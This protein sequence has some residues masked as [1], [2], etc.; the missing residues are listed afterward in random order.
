V[1]VGW[2]TPVYNFLDSVPSSPTLNQGSCADWS[3]SAL[4]PLKNEGF[5]VPTQV[6]YVVKGGPLWLPGEKIPGSAMVVNNFLRNGYLWDTVRVMGGA[7]GGFSSFSRASGLFS[8][9]SYRDPNLVGT[10]EAYDKAAD[11]LVQA[12]V[13]QDELS[14]SI[15]GTIG[16][17][18]SP[19]SPDQKG[20][21]SMVQYLQEE[22]PED[23]QR[24]RDEVLS[25]SARDF[26]EFG[27]RLGELKKR[28]TTAVVGSRKSLAEANEALPKDAKLDVIELL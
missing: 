28:A 3:K 11:Y 1:V 27:E 24:W 18:D 4:S 8:F 21:T 2:Q 14:Q 15:I 13:G 20:F 10:F 6:N 16:D 25:T 7:Y 26:K 22:S 17:L 5:A 23:R 12:E 9:G 19:Q